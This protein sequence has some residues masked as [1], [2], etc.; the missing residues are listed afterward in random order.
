M[1]FQ[2]HRDRGTNNET[3]ASDWNWI[4]KVDWE[5]LPDLETLYLDFSCTGPWSGWDD[6]P[7]SVIPSVKDCAKGMKCLSLKKLVLMNVS[8]GPGG[9][10][11]EEEKRKFERLWKGAFGDEGELVVVMDDKGKW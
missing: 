6:V 11:V 7:L 2:P 4:L 9:I 10:D 5:T 8:L 3:E 1:V